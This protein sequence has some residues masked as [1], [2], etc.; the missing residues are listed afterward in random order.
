MNESRDIDEILASLD[1]LLR[2]GS[3]HH[4]NELLEPA[5]PTPS[6]AK[7]EASSISEK[8]QK[9]A[10]IESKK[11]EKNKKQRKSTVKPAALPDTHKQVHTKDLARVLLTK[12]MLVEAGEEKSSKAKHADKSAQA[13]E[14][15]ISAETASTKSSFKKETVK[16]T[17]QDQEGLSKN[18]PMS[19]HHE[20]FMH[21]QQKDIEQLLALVS[22]DISNHLQK[23]LPK[24]IHKSLHAHLSSMQQ[25][26]KKIKNVRKSND[27][28]IGHKL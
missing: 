1:T 14:R 21:L 23:T 17:V 22:R 26:N 12:D 6:E 19:S 8:K 13:T 9:N 7:A 20:P 27:E 3:S 28:H 25:P 18:S 16:E 4:E 24:L 11:P 10:T 15:S 2:E 5:L